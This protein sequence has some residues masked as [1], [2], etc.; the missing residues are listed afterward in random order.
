MAR[1]VWSVNG[2]EQI[3][4][5]D[6]GRAVIGSDAGCA[7]VLSDP[8]VSPVHCE[9]RRGADG[10]RVVDME[11]RHGTQVDGKFVN[12]ALL[13]NGTEIRIGGVR[14]TFL[15]DAT[16][17]RRAAAPGAAAPAAAAPVVAPVVAVQAASRAP[18]AAPPRTR[19]RR[20]GDGD[21]DAAAAG[22]EQRRGARDRRTANRTTTLMLSLAGVLGG[23]LVVWFMVQSIGSE[24]PN[25]ARR[26]DI[27]R[28]ERM[29]EWNTVLAIAAEADDDGSFDHAEIG[30][31]AERAR[32]AL[33][34]EAA[35]KRIVESNNAWNAV[36]T[37]RQ[38]N[39][40]EDG[41]YV[42]RLDEYLAAWGDLGSDGVRLARSERLKVAGSSASAAGPGGAWGAL[43]ED[44]KIHEAEGSFAEAF[45]KLDAFDAGPGAGDPAQR[46]RSDAERVRL[47][48]SATRWFDKQVALSRHYVDNGEFNKARKTLLQAADK[49]GI[50][51]L[52]DRA[53][54]EMQ[55]LQ[56]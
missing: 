18:V 24:T 28:A 29:M 53:R 55:K 20:E 1:L 30:K 25:H 40:S 9:L 23:F 37:W 2:E 34:A 26:A 6:D 10:W 4:V 45:R 14:A 16:D 12:Q 19:R 52:Q 56:R 42:R 11:S 3:A 15:L 48:A 36:R 17:S 22:R 54:E 35:G 8:Q 49:V 31:A 38:E 41:E 5:L 47:R 39:R 32:A 44:V 46:A 27:Q 50:A 7:I 43:V 33:A 21:G 13:G 51:E